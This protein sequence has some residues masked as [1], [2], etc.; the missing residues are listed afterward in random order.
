[1]HISLW[2]IR[3]NTYLDEHI[4]GVCLCCILL[5]EPFNFSEKELVI[6][7]PSSR[8]NVAKGKNSKK[9]QQRQLN[10]GLS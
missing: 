6:C 3:T 10:K 8:N 4:M 2:N 7:D 9:I 1:M 5:P